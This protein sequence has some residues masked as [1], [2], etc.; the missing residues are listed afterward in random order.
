MRINGNSDVQDI[1]KIN[2]T[3]AVYLRWTIY[4]SDLSKIIRISNM[5]FF[6]FVLIKIPS[7]KNVNMR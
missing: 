7:V 4:Y 3:G 2:N 6:V 1:N 5:Q